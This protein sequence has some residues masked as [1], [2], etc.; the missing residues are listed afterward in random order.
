MLSVA[1]L[2]CVAAVRSETARSGSGA[3]STSSAA[4][5]AS[6]PASAAAVSGSAPAAQGPGTPSAADAAAAAR[7][8]KNGPILKLSGFRSAQFGMDEEAVRAAIQKDFGVQASAI[9]KSSALADRTEV[10]SIHVPEVLPDGGASDVTYS[11][12]Y[13]SKK[14]AQVSVVWSKGTDKAIT[15]DRLLADGEALKDYFQGAGYDPKSLAI[16]A[17]VKDG[18][19]LFRGTDAAGHITALM[20]HGTM[21]LGAD[22]IQS[23]TP[24]ALMLFYIADVKAPDVFRI[25]AGR[26]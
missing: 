6:A 17:A 23:F 21:A 10:L 5:A 19:L 7:V 13:R 24:N 18:V 15:P 25:E 16:N 26:F 14:L 12:G 1:T 3:K 9:R 8:D 22:K 20:L 4:A 11:F 2:T